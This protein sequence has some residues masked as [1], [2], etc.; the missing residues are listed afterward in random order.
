MRASVIRIAAPLPSRY[1]EW[2]AEV[3]RGRLGREPWTA[4]A[5]LLPNIEIAREFGVSKGRAQGR[6]ALQATRGSKVFG[7]SWGL[8]EISG[9]EG[10]GGETRSGKGVAPRSAQFTPE[11]QRLDA[12]GG[13]DV[14]SGGEFDRR[15]TG[16]DEVGGRVRGDDDDGVHAAALGDGFEGVVV[17]GI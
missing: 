1:W 14:A 11:A 12:G 10:A 15:A 4:G 2:I 13:N 16:E 7:Q 9:A 17:L 3:W 8:R 6:N 5:R